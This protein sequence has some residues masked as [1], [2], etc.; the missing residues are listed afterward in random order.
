MYSRIIV[1]HGITYRFYEKRA[2][3]W[4]DQHL[5]FIKLGFMYITVPY[6]K[7]SY[8]TKYPCSDCAIYR[9]NIQFGAKM[10]I[11]IYRYQKFV[12]LALTWVEFFYFFKH[13]MRCQFINNIMG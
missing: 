2:Y 4:G 6:Q 12:V 7:Y 5:D 11:E 1:G 3:K 8:P 9:L 13:S 10:E